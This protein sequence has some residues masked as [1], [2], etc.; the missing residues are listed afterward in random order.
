MIQDLFDKITDLLTCG[1]TGAV[2]PDASTCGGWSADTAQILNTKMSDFTV[3]IPT[4]YSTAKGYARRLSDCVASYT[5]GSGANA[6]YSG[7]NWDNDG[8]SWSASWGN[9][10]TT[11]TWS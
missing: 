6:N 3:A 2:S 8:G 5:S 4:D 7:D 10:D 11:W 9:S 1:T